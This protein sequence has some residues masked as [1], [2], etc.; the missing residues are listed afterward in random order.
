VQKEGRDASQISAIELA[1]INRGI[2]N[3]VHVIELKVIKA[4]EGNLQHPQGVNCEES[5]H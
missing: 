2:P 3:S 1:W 5:A 4:V